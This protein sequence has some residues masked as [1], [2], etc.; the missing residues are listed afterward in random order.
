M[1]KIPYKD[2]EILISGESEKLPKYFSQIINLIN[3]NAQATRPNIVGQLS[4][5]I[6]ECP[7]RTFKGWRNWYLT[8]Y[9]DA[10]NN[11]TDKI[12][13]K[14]KDM[15]QVLQPID[16]DIIRKWV[17][18]LVIV[19]TYTGLRFQEAIIKKLSE[20]EGKSYRLAEPVEESKGIDGYIGDEPVSIKPETYKTKNMLP[21]VIKTRIIYYSKAKDG[22]LVN[23]EN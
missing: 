20:L 9:P 13:E 12:V 3:Q 6:Q 23:S 17:E 15:K 2:I 19:K 4:E 14:M 21:E 10:I 8:K 7:Y 1:L 5:F 18:D 16:R 22:I 11:A